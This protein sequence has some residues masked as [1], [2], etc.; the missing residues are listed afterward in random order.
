[1]VVLA[2]CSQN[3]EPNTATPAPRRPAR[4]LD[5]PPPTQTISL[6]ADATGVR[7]KNESEDPLVIFLDECTGHRRLGLV[8]GRGT[9]LFSLPPSVYLQGSDVVLHA[10]TQNPG[11]YVNSTRHTPGPDTTRIEATVAV[12]TQVSIGDELARVGE[13][14]YGVQVEIP[15]TQSRATLRMYCRDDQHHLDLGG[16]PSDLAPYDAELRFQPSD[17]RAPTNPW[18]RDGDRVALPQEFAA[19]VITRMRANE[20][21]E[22]RLQATGYFTVLTFPLG[23]VTEALA[24]LG[25]APRSEGR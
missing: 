4:G 6:G 21:M 12:Q 10:F 19:P 14:E 7:V 13:G 15:D 17:E 18:E 2:A 8:Q 11:I 23:G 20:S 24:R 9:R 3:P 22:V 16:L 1:M 25:C 5:C